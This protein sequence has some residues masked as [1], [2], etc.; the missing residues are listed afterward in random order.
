MGKQ[1]ILPCCSSELVCDAITVDITAHN[2]RGNYRHTHTHTHSV[3]T[4]GWLMMMVASQSDSSDLLSVK[5]AEQNLSRERVSV[6]GVE[7][8]VL[9]IVILVIA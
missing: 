8:S 2:Q 3:Y 1:N 4:V 6:R 7:S 5:S 9:L